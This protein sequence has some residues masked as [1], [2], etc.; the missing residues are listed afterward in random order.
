MSTQ[1][2]GCH[3]NFVGS[4][5]LRHLRNTTNP[6]CLDY[7]DSL[8]QRSFERPLSQERA[9]EQMEDRDDADHMREDL[10][11]DDSDF[12]GK[13]VDMGPVNEDVDMG[14]DPF[15]Q[16]ETPAGAIGND[17][18]SDSD[19]SEGQYHFE[20]ADDNW[21]PPPLEDFAHSPSP[22]SPSPQ[23]IFPEGYFDEA[24]QLPTPRVPSVPQSTGMRKPY[25]Q[26][27]PDPR[28]GAP[29]ER[30][31]AIVNENSKYLQNLEA[32]ANPWA[33]FG[34]QVEWE[35]ARWAKLRGPSSTAL[36]ELLSIN[37]VCENLDLSYSN[38]DQLNAIIDKQLPSTCPKFQRQ[39]V[40]VQGQ[41][42]EMY[43]RDIIECI[44]SLYGDAEFAEYLKFAPER[45][46]ENA[47]CK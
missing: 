47:Q 26:Q 36:T 20:D 14:Q 37:G 30:Q 17:F 31:G 39:E 22:R 21:E 7:L 32:G 23:L 18:D 16:F 35:I 8:F 28:A 6:A 5:L 29:V 33:P 4:N 46:Y 1:C 43:F 2:H 40:V 3:K 38:A 12:D 9:L 42:Y 11:G 24:L 25:I 27:Y 19:D 15:L 45:H 41:A 34:S 44:K 13:D 10:F